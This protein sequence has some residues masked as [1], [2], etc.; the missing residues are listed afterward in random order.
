MIDLNVVFELIEASG[1]TKQKA[2]G[3]KHLISYVIEKLEEISHNLDQAIEVAFNFQRG[4]KEAG[5]D[6]LTLALSR[7]PF[8]CSHFALK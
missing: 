3:E 5:I 1:G 2:I 4:E 7:P 8:N 6:E